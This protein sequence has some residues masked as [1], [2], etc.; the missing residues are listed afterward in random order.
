MQKYKYEYDEN[1]DECA[2]CLDILEE[3]IDYKRN[4][5][6]YRGEKMYYYT[7]KDDTININIKREYIE[8]AIF[9]RK[10]NEEFIK[11]LEN[12]ERVKAIRMTER[13]N[14]TIQHDLKK[15]SFKKIKIKNDY[16]IFNKEENKEKQLIIYK[17][18]ILDKNYFIKKGKEYDKRNQNKIIDDIVLKIEKY[19]KI[20]NNK[21]I[22]NYK[23]NENRAK[24]KLWNQLLEQKDKMGIE[25]YKYF[26]KEETTDKINITRFE[27]ISKIYTKILNN[28]GLNDSKYIFLPY[29]FKDVNK[30]FIDILIG[31]LLN[32]HQIK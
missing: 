27:T 2:D 25:D 6:V 29:T 22:Y 20:N 23:Y 32:L 9:N 3:Y 26:V 12:N 31:K 1:N 18:L 11:E 30:D 24:M 15:K 16:K 8:D 14:N 10:L 4:G 21:S 28:K 5:N 17:P 19:Y 13:E 7:N